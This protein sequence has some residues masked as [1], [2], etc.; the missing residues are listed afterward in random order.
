VAKTLKITIMLL[1]LQ[2]TVL[3]NL[4]II[5]KCSLLTLHLFA[6]PD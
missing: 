4:A 6:E 5:Y 1:S 2:P 3:L